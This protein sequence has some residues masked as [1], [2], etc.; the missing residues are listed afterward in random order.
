MTR[1]WLTLVLSAVIASQG[2]VYSSVALNTC[3]YMQTRTMAMEHYSYGR[4]EGNPI[5]TKMFGI[6]PTAGELDM[7]FA[8]VTAGLV[9]L[10]M[11]LPKWWRRGL[12]ALV[13][14]TQSV[15]VVRNTGVTPGL[16]G[17]KTGDDR[18]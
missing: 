5:V 1:A 17:I 2:C 16:C 14:T 6:R 7:Y 10:N 18:R 15:V 3:D 13:T 9:L 4:A 8:S 12:N 11:V